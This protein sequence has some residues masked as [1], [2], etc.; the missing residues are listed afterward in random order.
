MVKG[1]LAHQTWSQ[2]IAGSADAA[3]RSRIDS[4]ESSFIGSHSS[5][6]RRSDLFELVIFRLL[7]R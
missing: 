4:I 6:S 7:Y 3:A 2:L 5:I 1:R